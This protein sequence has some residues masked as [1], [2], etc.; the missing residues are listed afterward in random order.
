MHS[1]NYLLTL[2]LTCVFWSSP[3][4]ATETEHNSPTRTSPDTIPLGF[5]T[6]IRRRL[7]AQLFRHARR[8]DTCPT[9]YFQC[10]NGLPSSFCCANGDSCVA[11]AN[12]TSALCCPEGQDC[13]KIEPISC[14]I[15]GQNPVAYPTFAVHT[16]N[17][18]GQ[19]PTCGTACCPF[20]Y[21]CSGGD[22]CVRTTTKSDAL[23]T[24]TPSS[25]TA[26]TA[27]TGSAV[28]AT[29]TPKTTTNPSDSTTDIP[30]TADQDNG[31]ST[32]SSGNDRRTIA[33]AAGSSAAGVVSIGAI[34]FF[35][36]SRRRRSA[37]S[38][39]ASQDQVSAPKFSPTPPPLP[40]KEPHL[41]V[42]RKRKSFLSWVPSV[43]NRAPAELPA[44]PVSF[45]AWS[46]APDGAQWGQVQ[47]PPGAH[48]PY[49]RDSLRIEEVHELEADA[50]WLPRQNFI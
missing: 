7:G 4:F 9:D 37:N 45:S 11:L 14:N 38:T 16:T 34:L 39:A 21:S 27:S 29:A 25:T 28:L 1:I 35:A 18:T 32:S 49:P 5:P 44:T 42:K 30:G 48:R 24:D 22:T 12:N 3:T 43:I 6:Q 47:L 19:L 46:P 41:V 40:E 17:L 8:D 36:W 33:I 15:D 2:L 50:R 13:S 31:S 10:G 23:V 20:G 26:S